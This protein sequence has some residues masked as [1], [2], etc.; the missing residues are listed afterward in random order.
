MSIATRMDTVIQ[1]KLPVQLM[2]MRGQL[3]MEQICGLGHL[4]TRLLRIHVVLFAINNGQIQM[5]MDLVIT[6]LL[7]HSSEM[8]SP[9][10]VGSG[11]I[12]ITMVLEII[13]MTLN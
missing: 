12:L 5:E 10:M 2:T 8:H 4:M 13:G 1:P 7:V 11:M 3:L 6:H 9:L